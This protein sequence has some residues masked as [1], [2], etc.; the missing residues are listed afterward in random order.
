MKRIQPFLKKNNLGKTLKFKDDGYNELVVE[1]IATNPNVYKIYCYDMLCR[2]RY[3]LAEYKGNKYEIFNDELFN[4]MFVKTLKNNL[5]F[6]KTYNNFI[7]DKDSYTTSISW[8][9]LIIDKIKK[10]LTKW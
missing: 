6:S 7:S 10:Y 5:D 3:E 4:E 2:V 8:Y 1:H 9:G